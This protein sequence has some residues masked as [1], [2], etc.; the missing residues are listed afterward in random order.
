M[1]ITFNGH[2]KVSGGSKFIE[3]ALL[4]LWELL[5]EN[6]KSC[7]YKCNSQIEIA[8]VTN[9]KL[10]LEKLKRIALNFVYTI[11]DKIWNLKRQIKNVSWGFKNVNLLYQLLFA[12]RSVSFAYARV[13]KEADDRI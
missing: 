1:S 6:V 9:D 10:F 8:R 7:K 2:K 5:I 4:F 12:E 3:W 13:I 11:C